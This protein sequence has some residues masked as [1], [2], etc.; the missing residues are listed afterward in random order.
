MSLKA[1]S[2]WFEAHQFGWRWLLIG[3]IP[4]TI[5]CAIALAGNSPLLRLPDRFFYDLVSLR[6]PG[7]APAVVIVEGVPN[8]P[9]SAAALAKAAL[10]QGIIRVTFPFDP[11]IDIAASGIAADRLVIGQSAMRAPGFAWWKFTRDDSAPGSRRGAAV[12]ARADYGLHRHQLA[13]LAGRTGRIASFESAAAGRLPDSQRFLVRISHNQN[14]PRIKAAQIVGGELGSGSLTG[15][16]ALVEPSPGRWTAPLATAR[17]ADGSPMSRI[18]FSAA[19]I[20]TLADGR[21][22]RELG[23]FP[24][25]VLLLVSGLITTLVYVRYDPKKIIIPHLIASAVVVLGGAAL[26]IRFGTW[27]LPVTGLLVA[28]MLSAFLV[29]YRMEIDEDFRLRRF[30]NRTVAESSRHILTKDLA[31]IPRFAGNLAR[32]LG[33]ERM[34]LV[35]HDLRGGLEVLDSRGG[36]QED[37]VASRRVIRRLLRKASEAS[38]PLDAAPLVPGWPAE[39]KVAF[40]GEGRSD[41]FWIYAFPPGHD[42][43]AAERFAASLAAGYRAILDLHRESS[44][45]AGL[46]RRYRPVDD[47]AGSAVELATTHGN[48]IMGGLDELETAVMVFHRI[49]FPLHANVKMAALYGL[50]GLQLADTSIPELVEALTDLDREKIDAA[51]RELLLDGGE[52]RMAC[53]TLDTRARVLRMVAAPASEA[54]PEPAIVVEVFDTTEFRRLAELQRSVTHFLDT[55]MRNDLEAITL[56][57]RIGSDPRMERSKLER[58]FGQLEAATRRAIGRLENMANRVPDERSLALGEPYPVEPC[59]VVRTACAL[60]A[61][62]AEELGV[63]IDVR[64]P[65]LSG[66][67]NAEPGTLTQLVEALLRIVATDTPKGEAV[68]V[69]LQEHEARTTLAITGGIGMPF[70]RLYAAIEPNAADAPPQFRAASRGMAAALHWGAMVSHSSGVGK[71]Y[72]FIIDMARIQ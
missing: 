48:R 44:P 35:E 33:I 58:V 7:M 40:L 36:A 57:V 1:V 26:F 65:D 32:I 21:G 10:Q 16:I 12:L 20:Q 39:S 43:S 6:E 68:G 70:D 14:L 25:F 27:L 53:R 56:A 13:W 23:P 63:A 2:A 54:H 51:L 42:D 28:Q 11:G 47:W 24:A 67:V 15:K 17:D 66:F 55:Q 3:I 19:A 34:L 29:L 49:G 18:E 61:P 9:A 41:L 64:M 62:L 71:G 5:A 31:R 38:E 50:A 52:M 45:S 8:D 59:E 30:V 60:A 69:L 4:T 46:Q 72:R 22:V 37:V